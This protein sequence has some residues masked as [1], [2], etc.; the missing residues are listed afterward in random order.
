[1]STSLVTALAALILA[2]AG[3]SA[4]PLPVAPMPR[5]A[6]VSSVY[7]LRNVAAADVAHAL[8]THFK[9]SVVTAEPVSNTL[10]LTADPAQ[11][12]ILKMLAAIDKAPPQFVVTMVIMKAK[13]GFAEDSGI[14]ERKD[15]D[16]ENVWV[17]S[18]REV[19]MFGS[20]V[21]LAKKDDGLDIL[22]QPRLQVGENQ[23][24]SIQIGDGAGAIA[25]QVNPRLLPDGRVWL[26]IEMRSTGANN[27]HEVKVNCMVA[28]GGTLIVR[29]Q[30]EKAAKG[31]SSEILYVLTVHVV[32]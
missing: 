12:Q 6:A 9:R 17:L 1:M 14:A 19:R 3:S 25:A 26:Q 29:G 20:S 24:G 21:R 7:R 18:A 8:N 27:S 2:G 30:T 15:D 23:T 28:D 5:V 31:E 13:A 22:S 4:D 16:R 10:L 32:K 11:E